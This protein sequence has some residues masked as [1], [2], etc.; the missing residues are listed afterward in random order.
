MEKGY[1]EV[2]QP[3]DKEDGVWYIHVVR[4]LHE[5]DQRVVFD[6]AAQFRNESINDALQGPDLSNPQGSANNDMPFIK[7]V[8]Q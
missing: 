1:A 8:F 5:I 3:S 7:L 6:C 4:H 2:L